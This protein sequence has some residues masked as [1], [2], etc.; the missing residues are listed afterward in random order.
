MDTMLWI[1]VFFSSL[2]LLIKSANYF[3]IYSE[4]IGLL[5]GLSSFIIGATIVSIGTSLP[6]LMSSLFAIQAGETNFV[7]DN[8]IGT[9]ISNALLILGISGIATKTLKFN[10]SLIDVDLPFFF[11]SVALFGYFAF[12]RVISVP[13]GITLI[14]FFGVF[15]FY[16]IRQKPQVKDSDEMAK[17]KKQHKPK[18]NPKSVMKYILIIIL[19]LAVLTF[20]AKYLVDSILVLSGIL[21]IA[22]STLTITIVALGTSLPEILTSVAAVRRGNHGMAI[23]TV[24]GSNTFNLL[25][26]IGLPALITPLVVSGETLLIGLPFL[27]IATFVS[28]FVTLDD[29]VRPWEGV[30]MILLYG[31]FVAKIVG[32]M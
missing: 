21:N 27:I 1:G 32:I 30:A 16:T 2:F 9:N 7:V 28:I 17:L 5:L 15:L 25:F 19:S 3:T 14:L 24:L 12:D 8:I 29:K 11:I 31:V 6:E 4:K 20:S 23:G 18:K 13:E 10:T 26:V 22:S